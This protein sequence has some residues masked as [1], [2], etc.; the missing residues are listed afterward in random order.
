[1]QIRSIR[2]NDIDNTVEIRGCNTKFDIEN[3]NRYYQA[4]YYCSQT[5]PIAILGIK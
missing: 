2:N 4:I 3:Q 1:M 5:I